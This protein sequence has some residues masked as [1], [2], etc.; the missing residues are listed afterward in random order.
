MHQITNMKN[1]KHE[2]Q[3]ILIQY[4]NHNINGEVKN[5]KKL[6]E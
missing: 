2:K 4:C 6:P 1:Y 5:N 3:L